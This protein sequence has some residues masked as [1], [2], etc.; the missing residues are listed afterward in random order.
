MEFTKNDLSYD[1]TKLDYQAMLTTAQIAF[2]H[3]REEINRHIHN[4]YNISGK[5]N[6]SLEAKWIKE[7]ADKLAIIAETMDTLQGGLT[8]SQIE[9]VNK[10]EVKRFSPD[11][12][13]D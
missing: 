3:T 4:T 6:Y 12:E 7:E 8:R 9:V 2:S 13:V 5:V 11:Y 10:P 1:Q